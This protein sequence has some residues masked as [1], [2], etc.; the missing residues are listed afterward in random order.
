MPAPKAIQWCREAPDRIHLRAKKQVRIGLLR[1]RWRDGPAYDWNGPHRVQ[2]MVRDGRFIRLRRGAR[3]RALSCGRLHDESGDRDS[4]ADDRDND[5]TDRPGHRSWRCNIGD[6]PSPTIMGSGGLSAPIGGAMTARDKKIPAINQQGGARAGIS[7][8][9]AIGSTKLG[10][11]PR[12]G[13]LENTS[14][15]P[16]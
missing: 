16:P 3:G 15:A 7:V 13:K 12:R 6:W 10:W 2:S 14:Q 5:T 1:R 11:N 9:I 4:A 8:P